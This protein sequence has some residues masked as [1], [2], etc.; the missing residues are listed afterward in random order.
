MAALDGAGGETQLPPSLPP[1]PDPPE[2]AGRGPRDRSD[3]AR[4][5]ALVQHPALGENPPPRRAGGTPADRGRDAYH[6]IGVLGYLLNVL[7][8]LAERRVL[9]WHRGWRAATPL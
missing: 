8:M 5:C 6:L 4:D 3:P 1:R 2:P 7:F 9:A